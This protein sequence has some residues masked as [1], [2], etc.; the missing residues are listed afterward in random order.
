MSARRVEAICEQ[1]ADFRIGSLQRQVNLGNL[2][3]DFAVSD[4]PE[5]MVPIVLT[6]DDFVVLVSGDPLRT[7]A[8][9]FAHNGYLGFPVAAKINLPKDWDQRIA[10]L[11]K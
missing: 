5:R 10:R 3:R 7:N 8:Y 6:P 4:D 11:G 2:P 9:T 1:W